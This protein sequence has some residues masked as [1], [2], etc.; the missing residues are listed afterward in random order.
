M[1]FLLFVFV[2]ARVVD[3]V[4]GVCR[5]REWRRRRGVPRLC[6][7]AVG[8]AVAARQPKILHGKHPCV[9]GQLLGTEIRVGDPARLGLAWRPGALATASVPSPSLHPLGQTS[10]R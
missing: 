2:G 9:S 4:L 6:Y 1:W 7:R 5:P 8:R 10:A 3:G